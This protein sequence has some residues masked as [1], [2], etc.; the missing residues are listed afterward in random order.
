MSNKKSIGIALL[1]VGAVLLIGS[2]AADAIGI[3]GVASFGYKQII[4]A[5]VGVI[6]AIVGYLLYSKK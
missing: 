4:G 3:G 5:V 6:V 2:L 1:A